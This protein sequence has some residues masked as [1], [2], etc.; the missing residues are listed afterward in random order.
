MR[1]RELWIDIDDDQDSRAP[2]GL[3]TFDP[4]GPKRGA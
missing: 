4:Y 3:S 1:N 2:G